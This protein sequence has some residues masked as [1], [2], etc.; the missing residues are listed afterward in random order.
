MRHDLANTLQAVLHYAGT[1]STVSV[2]PTGQSVQG[3]INPTFVVSVGTMA[4]VSP[5][6]RFQCAVKEADELNG[7][8]TPVAGVDLVTDPDSLPSDEIEDGVFVTVDPDNDNDVYRATY[9]G[10]KPFVRVSIIPVDE[11]S[12]TPITIVLLAEPS[13]AP[14]S[15]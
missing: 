10:S 1:P 14:A 5:N 2:E 7:A 3:L 8:Y 13:Q 4:A 6:A 12:A 11:P 15:T 9:K